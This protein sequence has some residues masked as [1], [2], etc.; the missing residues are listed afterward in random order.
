MGFIKRFIKS[1]PKLFSTLKRCLLYVRYVKS[2]FQKDKYS[3]LETYQS[4]SQ[5]IISQ[6]GYHCF[7]GYYD[8]SPING[9]CN[10]IAF[11]R[12][13]VSCKQ[14]D[15]ADICVYDINSKTI[16]IV[17]HTHTWNWQQG[18]MLQWLDDNTLSFNDYENGRYIVA[19]FNIV[20]QKLIKYNRSVYSYNKSF[21]KYLSLN[22]YR[23][24]VYAKG[25]GYGYKTDSMDIDND[26]IWE[27]DIENNSSSLILSLKSVMLHEPNNYMECQHYINHVCYCPDERFIIFI[28]RWQKEGG[29]FSSRLLKYDLYNQTIKTLLNNGHVSHYCWKSNNELLIYATDNNQMKGYMVVDVETC[30]TQLVDGLPKEDGHPSYSSDGRWILTDTYPND[31]RK[32]YLFLFNAEIKKMYMLDAL[33]SPMKFFNENRCDF[34]PRW[35][36]DNKYICIDNTATGS[37]T[38]K[39]YKIS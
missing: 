37:R 25:Y 19:Q 15:V 26:G 8:K 35:S 21:S 31:Q 34:H 36:L 14:T 20:T 2:L 16:T 13:K 3:N 28:H 10:K 18:C 11:L 29:E 24:D 32:Q 33:H 5:F 30:Q 38:L 39:I 23:L 1:S 9:C 4:C 22:F 17:G 12:V 27:T 7:W 6:K